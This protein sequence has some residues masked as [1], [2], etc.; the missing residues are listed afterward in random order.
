M[1]ELGKIR[2]I[3]LANG[4]KLFEITKRQREI[5]KILNLELEYVSKKK[6]EFRI[7]GK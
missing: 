3:I 2:K 1:L 7:R 6:L 5:I 4:K